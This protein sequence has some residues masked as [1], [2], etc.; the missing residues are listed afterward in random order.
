MVTHEEYARLARLFREDQRAAL[1]AHGIADHKARMVIVSAYEVMSDNCEGDDPALWHISG[2]DMWDRL[3]GCGIRPSRIKAWFREGRPSE[4]F[5][6]TKKGVDALKVLQKH[7][8]TP[9]WQT[10]SP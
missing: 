9:Y 8:E 3:D 5:H 7:G 10:V 2:D 1:E 4:R 6:P